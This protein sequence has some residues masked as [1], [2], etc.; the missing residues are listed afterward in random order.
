MN[1]NSYHIKK[2]QLQ[3][4]KKT[5]NW[6]QYI[7]LNPTLE[8]YFNNEY[9]AW[10]H[11]KQS[12]FD[13]GLK[14]N[15]DYDIEN[16]NKILIVMPT[17]NRPNNIVNI[18]NMILEQTFINWFFLIIDD[19]STDS[20][21]VLFNKI[22]LKYNKNNK[23]LFLEN[24]T[25]YH[26]AK[27]LNRGID[28]LL[29]NY[30]THF[31]W[32]SDDNIYYPNFLNILV[33]NNIYF[34]Y[35]TFDVKSINT[36][37][38]INNT[39]YTDYKNLINT[40]NGCASFM[41]TKKAI[42][43]IGY[44]NETIPCCEDYDYIIRTFKIN[45]NTCY[46]IDTSLMM[47]IYHN[48]SL[49]ESNKSTIRKLKHKI[50]KIHLNLTK[51]NILEHKLIQENSIKIVSTN[52]LLTGTLMLQ[53][54]L[55]KLGLIS[56][57][58]FDINQNYNDSYFYIIL[59]SQSTKIPKNFI[60]W[61]IEQTSII[62]SPII[63]FNSNC[64]DKMNNSLSIFEISPDNISYYQNKL[65]NN[66][67]IRYN[68]LPFSD[69]YHLN[70][71][72]NDYEYDITFFGA[73]SSRRNIILN[74]LEHVL[75][76][77][78]KIKYLFGV[79]GEKRDDILK[80][81]K[82]VLNIHYYEDAK[83]ECDRF[84]IA[85]NCNCLILSENCIGDVQNK[86]N[87]K[88]FITYFDNIICS[89]N[90][91]NVEQLVSV[92][93]Y[94]LRDDVFLKN[95]ENYII[96]KQ[97]LSNI[98]LFYLHKNIVSLNYFKKLDISIDFNIDDSVFCISLIEDETRYNTMMLQPNVL[99]HTKFPAFKHNIGYIGCAMSYY[100]LMY[101]CKK[102]NIETI[103]IFEDD[104]M[105]NDNF[106][107]VY[108]I[109]QNFLKCVKWDI[110][111]GYC[112]VIENENDI[113][114]YYIY[115]GITFIKIKKMVGMVFNIYNNNVYDNFFEYDYNGAN[116]NRDNYNTNY[117]I[118]RII[119]KDDMNIFICY[120]NLVSILPV[121]SSLNLHN[122]NTNTL[123][124]YNWFKNEENKTNL[125]IQNFIQNNKPIEI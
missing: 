125:L 9:S 69:L 66:T 113:L 104:T 41:W 80:K 87:Y 88:Y 117:H 97:K 34:T 32:I 120:P 28:Y 53:D 60:F 78:Y 26:I 77:K 7:Q 123:F 64:F 109:T 19:G 83:L 122:K 68:Q 11:F 23:I 16:T 96:E 18:I 5:F 124:E 42:Q 67:K 43:Q 63:K 114:E 58:I 46:F 40:W 14:W 17:Y 100:T 47:Y 45:S 102:K 54:C 25:N 61:Q 56:E 22:K 36:R 30:F 103:T 101:N 20:N 95:K 92:I 33:S 115:K 76:T 84:N 1:N 94:N 82:Y 24:K 118:D 79:N 111:N 15:I 35:S 55:N 89:E 71:N 8:P 13:N 49:Y 106:N 91:V 121:K 90:D 48:E 31:T 4:I 86:E 75:S 98:S 73:K 105:F 99:S 38:S 51:E 65:I 59:Y 93:E 107:D 74:K 50:D 6:K 85:I 52:N 108:R 57:I 12:G 62:E 110:F 3:E 37:K 21:K 119:N 70:N 116:N 29:A 27:T 10:C 81:T 112:C 2:Q 72:I 44:Y 39:H